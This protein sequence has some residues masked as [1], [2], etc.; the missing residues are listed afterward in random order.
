MRWIQYISMMVALA[1]CHPASAQ[2]KAKI[3]ELIKKDRVIQKGGKFRIQ[4][5]HICKLHRPK[6]LGGGVSKP[7]QVSARAEAPDRGVVSRDNF[8]V[9]YT[10]I[11]LGLRVKFAADFIKGLTPVQALDALQCEPLEAASG[12]VD[13]KVAITMN[14]K[15]IKI[16]VEKPGTDN[17]QSQMNSWQ[18]LFG[19][20][21]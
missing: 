19:S 8:L 18:D 11:A 9:L 20:Q 15:G 6:H 2:T 16:Q 12:P 17:K 14:Q 7:F 13:L 1:F 5:Y 21:L 10:E 3:T 4:G